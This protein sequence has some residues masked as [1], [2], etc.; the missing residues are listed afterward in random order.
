MTMLTLMKMVESSSNELKTLWD[1]EKSL[2]T[3]NFH[4]SHSVFIRLILQT[5]KNQGLSGK[6]FN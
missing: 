2:V 5:H 1:K 3:S 6:Q 4:F